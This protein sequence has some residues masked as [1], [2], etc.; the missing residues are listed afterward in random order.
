MEKVLNIISGFFLLDLNKTDFLWNSQ[1]SI[2]SKLGL[3]SL[4]Q[5]DFKEMKNFKNS[6]DDGNTILMHCNH[7][8]LHLILQTI[9]KGR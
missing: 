1:N 5:L 8:L 3:L 4:F 7:I 9:L 2:I 6:Y